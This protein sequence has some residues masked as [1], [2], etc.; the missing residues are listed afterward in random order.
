MFTDR[1]YE[2]R[3]NNILV[4]C[5]IKLKLYALRLELAKVHYKRKHQNFY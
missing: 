2:T 1:K 3:L 5:E 4:N